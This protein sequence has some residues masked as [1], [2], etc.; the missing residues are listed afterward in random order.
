MVGYGIEFQSAVSTDCWSTV[1]FLLWRSPNI[2]LY[3]D[4]HVLLQVVSRLLQD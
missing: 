1:W 3:I 2:D 4:V